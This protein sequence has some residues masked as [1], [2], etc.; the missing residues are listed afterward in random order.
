MRRVYVEYANNLGI[1][2]FEAIEMN[3]EEFDEKYRQSKPDYI[4]FVKITGS[5]IGY[6]NKR[7]YW[8]KFNT[9]SGVLLD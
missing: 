6:A 5:K 2:G 3:Q 1:A 7:T 4:Q 9:D 8:Q